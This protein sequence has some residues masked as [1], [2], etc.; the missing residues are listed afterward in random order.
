MVLSLL[1]LEADKAKP[2]R[3]T[4]LKLAQVLGV[5]FAELVE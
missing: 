1:T 5:D 3:R 4:V 2:Q